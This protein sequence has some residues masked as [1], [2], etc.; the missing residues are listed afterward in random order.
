M[1]RSL[2]V[3][4][5][6]KNIRV[7]TISPGSIETPIFDKMGLPKENLDNFNQEAISK[8]ALKRFGKACEVAQAV[9]FLAS[10]AASSI[11][12]VELFVDG[13]MVEL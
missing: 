13:G 1:G 10:N 12:G 9:L 3:G 2:A 7:N 4:L 11:N 6:D 8:I 5:A